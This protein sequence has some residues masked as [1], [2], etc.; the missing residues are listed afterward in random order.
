MKDKIN[1]EYLLQRYLSNELTEGE[2]V[3][4]LEA[5]QDKA[6]DAVLRDLVSRHFSQDPPPGYRYDEARV[7]KMIMGVLKKGGQL[8][9]EE[10]VTADGT[11]E[12][13]AVETEA[14]YP[15]TEKIVHRLSYW[16]GRAVAAAVVLGV[17]LFIYYLWQQGHRTIRTEEVAA[18]QLD[19]DVLPGS[20]KAI[21][22]LSN[23]KQVVLDETAEQLINDGEIAIENKGGS[24]LYDRSEKVAY[25]TMTTPRGG[26]YKLKLA[27]GTTVWL[28][29]A[30]SIVYPTSFTGK[31]REVSITGEVYFEVAKNAAKPFIVKTYS[32][33]IVVKGTSFNVN[34]YSDETA[35]KT[36]LLEG[37][38][39][40][41]GKLLRPGKAYQGGVI[42]ETDI[43]RDLAWKNGVFNFHEVALKDAM[44]QIARWYDVE[45]HYAGNVGNILLGGE[46][47]R[48]LTLQQVLNGLQDRDI[49]FRLDGKTLM[50]Y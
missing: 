25:N 49:H 44:K 2:K 5:L 24:L 22:T 31:T 11:G 23:G 28:N 7:E 9:P 13:V 30:S 14:V 43:A 45:L 19:N 27:D 46:I 47:G 37:L 39:E 6:S 12:A 40:I 16:W 20:N 38:V 50:V 36:S 35:V 15:E 17:G 18:V 10:T 29:A 26:Q 48:N 3:K 21:L 34:S 8:P 4:L 1:F 42:A 41:N 33:E 32:D